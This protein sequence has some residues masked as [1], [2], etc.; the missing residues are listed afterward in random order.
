MQD[1]I[2]EETYTLIALNW[3]IGYLSDEE[4]VP[5]LKKCKAAL[6]GN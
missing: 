4:L 6:G 3:V 2:F 1:V 5:F